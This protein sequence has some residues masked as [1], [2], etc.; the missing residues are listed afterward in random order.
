MESLDQGLPE[1]GVVVLL[2]ITPKTSLAR[3]R[4]ERDIH[5][6]DL[7]YLEKVRGEYLELAKEGD[8]V[9]VNGEKSIEQ[10]S[11]GVWRALSKKLGIR[12]T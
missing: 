10:V 1:P 11:G 5:E 6:R 7:S 12:Q 2:D 8:W 4:V 9:V 3:K